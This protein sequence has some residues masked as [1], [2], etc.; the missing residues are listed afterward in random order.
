MN[1]RDAVLALIALST[2]PGF[3]NAQSAPHRLALLGESAAPGSADT[4][5]FLREGL[6]ENCLGDGKGYALDPYCA[7]DQG[8]LQAAPR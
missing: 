3:A 8:Q 4:L 1:R 7:A 2:A 5:A 6:P